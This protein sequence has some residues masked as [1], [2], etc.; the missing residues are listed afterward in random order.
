MASGKA[1]SGRVIPHACGEMSAKQT[2]GFPFPEEKCHKVTK[3][4]G[5][6]AVDA[7]L[8]ADGGIAE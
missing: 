3:G 2:K 1:P 8:G 7:T 6:V 5:R 4:D